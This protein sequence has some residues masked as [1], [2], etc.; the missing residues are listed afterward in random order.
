MKSKKTPATY[1]I[2]KKQ[3]ESGV[4]KSDFDSVV[5]TLLKTPPK[6]KKKT[7]QRDHG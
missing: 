3:T 5:G 7:A 2:D 1:K 4:T 6:P